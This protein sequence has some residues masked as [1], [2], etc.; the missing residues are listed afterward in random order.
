[1]PEEPET[2]SFPDAVMLNDGGVTSPQGN[3]VQT[4]YVDLSGTHPTG[5]LTLAKVSEP[6]YDLRTTGTVRL[7]RPGVFRTTGEVLIKDDQEGEARTETKD[8]VEEPEDR[9]LDRRVRG[10]RVGV[11]LGRSGLSI[12]NATATSSRTKSATERVTFGRDW[13]I[14]STSIWPHE[15]EQ[16]AWRGTFP[17]DYT[18]VVRLYRPAHFALALGLGICEHV[19]VSGKPAPMTGT[20]HGFRTV[21]V[22]RS[23]QMVLHG[24]VL[25]VEEPYETIMTAE[26]GWPQIC[27]MIFVKSR[28]YAAQKEYRF[29]VLSIPENVGEVVD[30]PVSGMMQDCLKP[31]KTPVVASEPEVAIEEDGSKAPEKRETSRS[32]TYRRRTVKRESGKWGQGD[33]KDG[34]E[35]VEIVE[36]TVTSPEEVPAPFPTEQKQPDVVIF[37]QGRAIGV[38]AAVKIAAAVAMAMIS[39]T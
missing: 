28:A 39:I 38:T 1:M 20:F 29:A 24:P 3:L 35:K 19:G 25:Y 32:Y 7:S 37:H 21:K 22:E 14:Y 30:L 34:R 10:L 16:E 36:E 33:E 27:S 8:T 4:N 17:D 12:K 18:S 2:L 31:V 23:A 11:R 26:E 9:D 5:D 6:Q 15:E 13:L